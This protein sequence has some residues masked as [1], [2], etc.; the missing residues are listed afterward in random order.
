MEYLESL[1]NTAMNKAMCVDRI[2]ADSN[3]IA[4][5]IIEFLKTEKM[6][7]VTPL[8]G[9]PSIDGH[10]CT[11]DTKSIREEIQ[12]FYQTN[13]YFNLPKKLTYKL[14]PSGLH[15][16]VAKIILNPDYKNQDRE[17]PDHSGE[18]LHEHINKIIDGASGNIL[19]FDPYLISDGFHTFG[20]LYEFRMMYNALLFNEWAKVDSNDIPLI[21]SSDGSPKYRVHKSRLHNDGE[22][23]FG[24]DDMFIVAAEIPKIGQVTNHY[25]V[26]DWHL[27]VIPIYATCLFEYDGHTST[28]CLNRMKVL[29][30]LNKKQ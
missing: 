17:K 19:D 8:L 24:R 3:S 13:P 18:M 26:K 6:T 20:E 25:N 21:L 29:I 7:E 22:Q 4:K 11:Y 30:E 9:H 10:P 2:R 23:P 15:G 1:L 28:D 12:G 5:F 27:F 14:M 16:K